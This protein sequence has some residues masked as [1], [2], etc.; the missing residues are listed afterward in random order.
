MQ[1]I[2][3]KVDKESPVVEFLEGIYEMNF[4]YGDRKSYPYSVQEASPEARNEQ[5]HQL[6]LVISRKA[7]RRLLSQVSV[8]TKHRDV[9]LMTDC[10]IS[11]K[12]LCS[13]SGLPARKVDA[14][15]EHVIFS[16]VRLALKKTR[17][18]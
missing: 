13:S 15:N 12:L 18:K 11:L 6:W 10:D 7:A 17:P 14:K 2:K 9:L 16:L 3:I 5:E 1:N 4:T 8:Q